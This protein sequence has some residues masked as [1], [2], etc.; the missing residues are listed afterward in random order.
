MDFVGVMN[1]YV[2][3]WCYTPESMKTDRQIDFV[4]IDQVLS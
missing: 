4:D 2:A 1:Q 3:K